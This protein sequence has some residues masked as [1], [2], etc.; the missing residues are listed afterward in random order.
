MASVASVRPLDLSRWRRLRRLAQF[1]LLHVGTA[2]TVVP[3]TSVLNRIMI[4]E[5]QLSDTLVAFLVTLPYWL[6]PLQ[7]WFGHAVDRRVQ[8]GGQR[9]VWIVLGGLLATSGSALTAPAVFLFP[10]G[11]GWG[12]LVTALA[13]LIWGGGINLA[14]VGY[15][16][17]LAEQETQDQRSRT[18]GIMFTCM[19]LSSIGAGLFLAQRLDP[20]APGKVI[21]AFTVVALVA[22]AAILLGAWR[23]EARHAVNARPAP[24]GRAA[25]LRMLAHNRDARRFFLYLLIILISIHTQDI[26]LEPYGAKVM[27]MSVAATARLISIWGTGFLLTLLASMW[28]VKAWGERRVIAMGAWLAAAAF[29]LIAA[30]GLAALRHVGLFQSAVLLLGLASGFLTQSNLTLMLR[31]SVPGARAVYVGAWGAANFLGQA[32]IVLPVAAHEGLSEL[33]GSVWAGYTFVFLL[34]AAGLLLSLLL[35]RTIS[36]RKFRD[37]ARALLHAAGV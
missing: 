35:L 33:T 34:E 6:A 3:V 1:T 22:L 13:F 14:S 20:Y 7:I 24:P 26:L 28:L 4:A 25:A 31:M 23:L 12:L 9:T 21:T 29:L 36:A 15:L 10:R 2:L 27:G 19:I 5:M 16:A 30:A 8:S 18:V 32:L 37:R 17:L 11:D